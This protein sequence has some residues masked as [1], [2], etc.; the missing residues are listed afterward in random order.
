[1]KLSKINSVHS[2]H[3]HAKVISLNLHSS[4]VLPA[5][6]QLSSSRSKLK[7]Q[8][9]TLQ[10]LIISWKSNINKP[11]SLE[12]WLMIRLEQ[13]S[14]PKMDILKSV[15]HGWKDSGMLNKLQNSTRQQ[16]SLT[17][18]EH[19]ILK[20][21]E[22]QSQKEAPNQS[23]QLHLISLNGTVYHTWKVSDLSLLTMNRQVFILI[24]ILNVSRPH[25]TSK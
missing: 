19:M 7:R 23:G 5:D 1:M 12:T 14:A 2:C 10:L 18:V 13:I 9:R 8:R 16:N 3:Q 4:S 20:M 22:I 24:L 25:T 6:Q 11:I 17:V 15:L 21:M